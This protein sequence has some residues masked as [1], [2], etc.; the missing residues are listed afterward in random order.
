MNSA[1]IDPAHEDTP[2][3]GDLMNTIKWLDPGVSDSALL[4]DLRGL[5]LPI[6]Q[7]T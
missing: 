3:S 5:G 6:P 2:S 4:A 7:D 1:T